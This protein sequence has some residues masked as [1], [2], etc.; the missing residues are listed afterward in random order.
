MNF[1]DYLNHNEI[2]AK[3]YEKL[4]I[5]FLKENKANRSEYTK[6]KDEYIK[7][8]FLVAEKWKKNL[9]KNGKTST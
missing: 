5:K 9:L 3:E 6:S 2:E 4:K 1:R 8:I 7:N